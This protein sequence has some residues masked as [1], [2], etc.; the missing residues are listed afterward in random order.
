MQR[1][2]N[3]FTAFIANLLKQFIREVEP[4]RRCGNGTGILGIDRLITAFVGFFSDMLN[5]GRQRN[6]AVF[7]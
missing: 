5:I 1:H 6:F 3:F 7:I 2:E 4:C